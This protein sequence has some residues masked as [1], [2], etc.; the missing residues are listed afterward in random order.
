MTRRAMVAGSG[1]LVA[2]CAPARRPSLKTGTGFAVSTNHPLAT[3]AAE[4][5][6]LA[7]GGAYDMMIAALAMSWV[8]DPANSSP[9]GRI[10]GVNAASSRI[11]TIHAATML[12]DVPASTVPV[13]GCIAAIDLCH[14]Q[15]RLSL[16]LAQVLAP[17]VATARQGH[18]VGDTL[19]AILATTADALDAGLRSIY[20]D[21]RG[22]PLDIV[23]NPQMADLIEMFGDSPDASAFWTRLN[24]A[25]SIPWSHTELIANQARFGQPLTHLVAGLGQLHSTAIIE[26]WGPWT[27]L[28]VAILARLNE[29]GLLRHPAQAAEAYAVSTILL[30]ERVPFHVGTLEPKADAPNADIDLDREA[31]A[32][33]RQTIALVEGTRADLWRTLDAT[34]FGTEASHT[35]DRNTTHF[36]VAEGAGMLAW[37]TSVGPWFG[38]R[39]SVAGAALGYSYAMRSG[40]RYRGQTHD[41][42]ELAPIII[43][44]AETPS[45]AI[46]AAGSERIL[47]ALTWVLAQA[48]RSGG[49]AD[50]ETLMR[51]PRL[52]PKDGALRMHLDMPADV[53]DHLAARGF[54]IQLT[55]YDVKQHLG[56]INF[57]AR[58]QAG[59]YYAGA[60][61]SSRGSALP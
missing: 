43:T 11:D 10:Q 38:S 5:M 44:R 37:T 27:M 29:A 36:S 3:R 13:P 2:A 45:L 61:P 26:T 55:D 59:D 28:G 49:H 33:A 47:G 42:T 35:D 4:E 32:I 56:I 57:V 39:R 1:A 51:L 16:P 12:R 30:L 6:K 41:G 24:A 21:D 17:A 53:R 34:Y 60:D 20:L 23:R 22:R 31:Q 18:R 15:Q 40:R 7:G 25:H 58:S 46:G 54:A 48:I 19:K 9:F 8:V 50:Y 52:F 14:S